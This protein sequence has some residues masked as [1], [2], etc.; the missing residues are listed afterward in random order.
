L[1]ITGIH[2]TGKATRSSSNEVGLSVQAQ[3]MH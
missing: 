2:L 1:S 3:P